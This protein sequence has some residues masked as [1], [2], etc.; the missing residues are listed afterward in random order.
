MKA[1]RSRTKTKEAD[2]LRV[3]RGFVAKFFLNEALAGLTS[4]RENQ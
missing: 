3:L 1:R 4:T 2:A